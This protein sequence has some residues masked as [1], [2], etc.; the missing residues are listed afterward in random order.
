MSPVH[1][2]NQIILKCINYK[3]TLIPKCDHNFCLSSDENLSTD[4]LKTK[5]ILW[6]SI[7]TLHLTKSRRPPV[8]PEGAESDDC[9]MVKELVHSSTASSSAAVAGEGSSEF[10][11]TGRLNCSPR[12]PDCVT[13]SENPVCLHSPLIRV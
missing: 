1:L 7:W 2:N 11:L 4:S 3:D 9:Q 10:I 12:H 5:D 13:Q 8:C 6:E